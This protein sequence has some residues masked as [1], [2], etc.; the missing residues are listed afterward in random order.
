MCTFK[1]R[2]KL[3]LVTVVSEG[4]CIRYLALAPHDSSR[5]H[6]IPRSN[7]SSLLNLDSVLSDSSWKHLVLGSNQSPFLHLALALSDSSWNIQSP[8]QH[9]VI[10]LAPSES[11]SL[12]F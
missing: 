10:L 8:F 1:L 4:I 3:G 6:S 7:R 12:G 5:E 2:L 9:L 11:L